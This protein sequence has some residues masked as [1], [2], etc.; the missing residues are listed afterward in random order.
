MIIKPVGG[1]TMSIFMERSYPLEVERAKAEKWP[2]LIPVGTMEYHSTHCPY[3]CDGLVAQGYAKKIA[4]QLD[5]VVMPTVWYGVASYAVGGPEKN[6]IHVDCD[7][8]EDYIYAILKS[9]FKCGFRRNIYLIISH[10]VEDY[11]PMT[12]ACMKAAKKLTMETLEEEGGYGWW[13]N[14]ENKDFYESLS[15][16]ESPWNWIRVIRAPDPEANAPFGG[17][18][19][20]GVNEC[21]ML[22]YFYP[23][24]I[25]LERLKDTNDWFAESAK[26]MDPKL[27][28]AAVNATLDKILKMMKE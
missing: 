18:D 6:T 14:N 21:S 28:K 4:E 16:S 24:S 3:G 23:G 12:L 1:K 17:G 26:D 2:V 7:V 22:E 15:G 13:G 8:M 20:A 9:L 10:Q 11:M 5:A 27:G 19:H 25:K